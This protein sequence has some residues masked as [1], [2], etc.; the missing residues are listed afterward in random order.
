MRKRGGGG[1]G[2]ENRK[3]DQRASQS[4][5]APE[6]RL[7]L[8]FV[9][10]RITIL[11]TKLSPFSKK[12][13]LRLAAVSSNCSVLQSVWI[14]IHS[15]QKRNKTGRCQKFY[16]LLHSTIHSGA[17]L[18]A[19]CEFTCQCR[20]C[21]FNPWVGKIPWDRKWQP[22]PWEIP[23]PWEIPWTE[24]PGRLQATE[25]QKSRT[26][27]SD[28]TTTQMELEARHW[29]STLTIPSVTPSHHHQCNSWKRRIPSWELVCQFTAQNLYI[30][31]HQ[32]STFNDKNKREFF[33]TPKW[34]LSS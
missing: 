24:E 23:L 11:S 27:L 31:V 28:S 5:Q 4:Y 22:T 17:S 14:T 13:S 30:Q 10:S 25:L 12:Y 19:Q 34:Q 20:R 3:H 33:S 21:G 18:V 2:Q 1:G 32:P 29:S 8:R 6:K 7:E 15:E 16:S 9:C 26:P